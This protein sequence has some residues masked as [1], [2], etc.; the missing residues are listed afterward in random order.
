MEDWHPDRSQV[1]E[2]PPANEIYSYPQPFYLDQ[3]P[4]VAR[5]MVR[6]HPCR[7][8]FRVELE[9]GSFRH[10]IPQEVD[11]I[12]LKCQKD[13]WEDEFKNE[14]DAYER[15]EDLQGHILPTLYGQGTFDGRPA[16]VLSHEA[17]PTLNEFAADIHNELNFETIEILLDDVFKTFTK[18]GAVYWDQKVDNFLLNPQEGRVIALDLEDVK[19]PGN[20]EQIDYSVNKGGARSLLDGMEATRRWETR[21]V[22]LDFMKPYRERRERDMKR[23]YG[24][25]PLKYGNNFEN[26]KTSNSPAY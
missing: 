14:R 26:A 5:K 23:Y 18:Y 17:G 10:N 22:D 1:R 19:F 20:F 21:P 8:V 16:L 12:I 3:H 7:G 13:D 15:L 9:P 4:I 24:H 2:I 11:T 6:Q 25:V